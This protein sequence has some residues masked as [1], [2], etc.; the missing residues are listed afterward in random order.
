MV[1]ELYQLCKVGYAHY[2]GLYD[3]LFILEFFT[4]Q[5]IILIKCQLVCAHEQLPC[6]K[7]GSMVLMWVSKPVNNGGYN[8]VRDKIEN[9]VRIMDNI[10][11]IMNF[12]RRK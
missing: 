1:Y 9:Y 4:I 3:L 6:S 2:Q 12:N 8:E 7:K 5:Y 11:F 10:V